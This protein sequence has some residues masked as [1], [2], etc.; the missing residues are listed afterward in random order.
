MTIT[1]VK[2]PSA[3]PRRPIPPPG[4]PRLQSGDRL[5]DAEFKRRYDAM[6]ASTKAELIEGAVYMPPPVFEES[7]GGPHADVM[8]WLGCYRAVT[9]GVRSADNTSL[10]LDLGTLPQ[11]DAYLRILPTHGG[12]TRIDKE[13]YVVGAPELIAEVAASSANYDLHDKL[14][15]YQRNGIPEYVVWRTYDAEID[16]FA[17]RGGRYQ[18][19]RQR[20]DGIYRSRILP[21]LWLNPTALLRGDMAAVLSVVQQGVASPE[22]ATFA[23]RLQKAADRRGE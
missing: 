14:T 13:G 8:T 6:P 2:T 18:R 15:A 9:P 11:P 19:L 3:L 20:R 5:S 23:R 16:W 10:R 4:I 12:K 1:I 21:G 22:H 7:H 17:L